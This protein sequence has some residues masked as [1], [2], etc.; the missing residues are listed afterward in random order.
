M[1]ERYTERAIRVLFFARA[2]VSEL[3]STTIQPEHL[4][5]GLLR[6]DNGL[7]GDILRPS[8][9]A[10]EKELNGRMAAQDDPI[11]EHVEIPFSS[12][13]KDILHAAQEEAD[14]L[15]HEHIGDGHLLLALLTEESSI[16]ASVLLA[17]G[18]QLQTMRDA[19]IAARSRPNDK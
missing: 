1:F 17:N 15:H 18:F 7:S 4:L 10:L 2:S 11:P 14:R 6:E 16:A 5:L 8:K 12:A 9:H 3:G 19:V 13:M